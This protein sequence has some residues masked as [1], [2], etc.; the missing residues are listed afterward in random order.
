LTAVAI[1]LTVAS[2]FSNLYPSVLVSSTSAADSLTVDSTASGPYALKVMTVVALVLLPV[3]LAYQVWTYLVFRHR[4]S[5][6]PLPTA[7][8]Q[9]PIEDPPSPANEG[10]T[11]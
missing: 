2:V 4:V 6:V 7:S 11:A 5:G 9:G 8:T 1:G 3:V 10:A